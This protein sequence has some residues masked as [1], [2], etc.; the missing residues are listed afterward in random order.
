MSGPRDGEHIQNLRETE[1]LGLELREEG[2][3]RASCGQS[4]FWPKCKTDQCL[5]CVEVGARSAKRNKRAS[6]LWRAM[7][8]K[9][10]PLIT[11]HMGPAR[12]TGKGL[13]QH[14]S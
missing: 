9:P 11:P 4:G 12:L 7:C 14:H 3:G 2:A 13:G 6:G 5:G 10:G 8:I 1:S